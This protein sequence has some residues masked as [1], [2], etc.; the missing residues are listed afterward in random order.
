MVISSRKE[1]NVKKAVSS[2]QNEGI[3][4]EGIVCHVANKEHRKKLFDLVRI[5]NNIHTAMPHE[6]KNIVYRKFY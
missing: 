6:G 2:L 1:E 4:V 3:T 5:V